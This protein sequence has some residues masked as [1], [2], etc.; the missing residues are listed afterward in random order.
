MKKLNAYFRSYNGQVLLRLI[1]AILIGYLASNAIGVVIAK[2]L[3]RW[4]SLH[5]SE[6]SL[7]ASLSAFFIYSV[8]ILWAFSVR[9][10]KK[11]WRQLSGLTF[12]FA[13]LAYVI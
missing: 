12:I 2:S 5:L 11:L 7:Y 4:T 9:S 8:I 1:A 6:A 3:D 10:Q 13:V